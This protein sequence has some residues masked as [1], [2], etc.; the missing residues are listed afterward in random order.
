MKKV[1]SVSLIFIMLFVLLPQ[2]V[3]SNSP[4][5]NLDGSIDTSPA[6]I[7][8]PVLIY[9]LIIGF[10]CLVEWLVSIPFAIHRECA[11]IILVTNILTQIGMH[12]LEVVYLALTAVP[13][14]FWL[15]F[16]AFIVILEIIVYATEFFIYY[17][18][19]LGFPTWSII[20]YTICANTASLLLGLLIIF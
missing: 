2:V 4:G 13:A 1:T 19:M 17:K 7:I 11:K 18:K 10:T 5:P 9:L 6:W 20:L 15:A 8:G 12:L 3:N 16:P 14:A